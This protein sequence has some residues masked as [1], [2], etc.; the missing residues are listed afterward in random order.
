MVFKECNDFLQQKK[1]EGNSYITELFCIGY[2]K[3][4]CYTFIN[5]HKKKNLI[6]KIS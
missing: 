2:I 5:M 3:S 6:L 1:N 4:F